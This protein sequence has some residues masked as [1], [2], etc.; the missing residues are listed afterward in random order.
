VTISRARSH[1]VVHQVNRLVV[2]ADAGLDDLHRR[3]ESLVPEIDADALSAL[4]EKSDLDQVRRYTAEGTP[5]TVARSRT[6]DPTP[7]MQLAGNHLQEMTYMIGNNVIIVERMFRHDPAVILYAG[8]RTAIH[9]LRGHLRR[10]VARVSTPIGAGH[11]A[12]RAGSRAAS[13]RVRARVG[14]FPLRTKPFRT[15]PTRGSRLVGR[16]PRDQRFVGA[17]PGPASHSVGQ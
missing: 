5:H 10:A 14:W 12:A 2:D 6:F 1:T 13:H 4:I 15:D 8:R 7:T 17:Q 3:N 11:R 16:A 9:R